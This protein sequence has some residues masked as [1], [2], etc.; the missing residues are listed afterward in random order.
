VGKHAPSRR[1]QSICVE[2]ERQLTRAKRGERERERQ[3][4]TTLRS[5]CIALAIV[6]S[7]SEPWGSSRYAL[8]LS[9]YS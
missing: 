1:I 9:W 7:A 8:N 5:V 6:S 2:E 3:G 4:R